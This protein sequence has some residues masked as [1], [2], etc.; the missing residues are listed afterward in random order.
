MPYAVL[1]VSSEDHALIRVAVQQGANEGYQFKTHPN[2]DKALYNSQQLLGLKSAAAPFPLGNS[3]PILKWRLEVSV[4]K[5]CGV[6]HHMLC[7]HG[8]NSLPG[9]LQHIR[10]CM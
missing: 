8:R 2:I 10:S 1:Q 3:L 6:F 4:L 9:D 7:M 5:Q